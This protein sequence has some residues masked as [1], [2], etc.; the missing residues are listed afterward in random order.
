ML[1]TCN[2]VESYAVPHWAK[3][4]AKG[5]KI[6][7][8]TRP[9]KWGLGKAT[10]R[11]T[12]ENEEVFAFNQVLRQDQLE[13]INRAVGSE[14]LGKIKAFL[15]QKCGMRDPT[16]LTWNQ[17]LDHLEVYLHSQKAEQA[18]ETKQNTTH[19]GQRGI[20]TCLKKVGEKALQIF[21]KSFWDAVLERV[22][23][24]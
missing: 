15:I 20:I 5:R 23:P 1:L 7:V 24:K 17:I 21:T 16:N 2:A 13:L 8:L 10:D 22:W 11:V 3:V 6:R 14:E 18:A 19:A 4:Q 12:T 9:F